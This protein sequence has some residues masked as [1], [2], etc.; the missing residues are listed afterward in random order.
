MAYK[1]LSAS[2]VTTSIAPS[3]H[4]PAVKPSRNSRK[5]VLP[6]KSKE[7]SAAALLLSGLRREKG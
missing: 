7:D 4:I 2:A 3:I 6:T 1:S 5:V